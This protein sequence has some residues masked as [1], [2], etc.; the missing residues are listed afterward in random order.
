MIKAG[1]IARLADISGIQHYVINGSKVLFLNPR[2]QPRP[3]KGVVAPARC[4]VDG[5]QLMDHG[6]TYCSLRCKLEV[7][8]ADFASHI[9]KAGGSADALHGAR[10]GDQQ[11]PGGPAPAR[12]PIVR[13]V[14]KRPAASEAMDVDT[15]DDQGVLRWGAA[16]GKRRTSETGGRRPSENGDGG[17]AHGNASPTASGDSGRSST[18]IADCRWH[19]RKGEPTRSPLQ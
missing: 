19:R 7:E 8:D 16:R 9:G 2:P 10:G 11:R 3:P 13:T 14:V 6:S 17:R 4:A 12:P 5:R 15:G 18:C 1:D